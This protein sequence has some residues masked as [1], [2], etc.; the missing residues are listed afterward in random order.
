LKTNY[1][2]NI[3]LRTRGWGLCFQGDDLVLT[4]AHNRFNKL[5][6]RD[7]AVLEQF[8]Q[9]SDED[10]REFIDEFLDD[11]GLKRA[12]AFLGVPREQVSI[13]WLDFPPEAE[14]TLD[15]VIQY[16]LET[17][18]PGH[19]ES[20]DFFHQIIS[21]T[22]QLKV[23]V[24]AV[25][26]EVMGKLF[27]LIHRWEIKLAGVTL[28]TLALVNGLARS[29]PEAFKKANW[30]LIHF[31]Q[32]AM[33]FI[34]IREGRLACSH[35]FRFQ[36]ASIS[37]SVVAGL[38]EG[39]A[40]TRLD[41]DEVEAFYF[42]GSPS[43]EMVIFL[44]DEI[45]I[46]PSDVLDSQQQTIPPVALG[47]FGQAVTSV[48]D[49]V[50]FRLNMLPENL[51]R[52]HRHLPLLVAAVL[53]LLFGIYLGVREFQ[54]YRALNEEYA[55]VTRQNAELLER[56][57]ELATIRAEHDRKQEEVEAYSKFRFSDGLVLKLLAS[58]AN[59]LPLHT[60]L[61][62]CGVK[63]GN[64]LTIQGES[65]EPF[66]VRSDLQALPYLRDVET[67]GPIS[68]AKDRSRKKFTF[69]AKIVLEALK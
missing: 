1:Q 6:Y 66:K 68:P 69:K 20:Y 27:S 30:A 29:S 8:E 53:V 32:D 56:L 47:G 26:K 37:E 63:N 12:E 28:D 38:E 4:A 7:Y 58:L 55:I 65:E 10:V 13:H 42:S 62:S 50:P 51:R 11:H 49:M 60:F 14:D 24:I 67:S 9:R 48:H 43:A 15:E 17:F 19:F 61:T 41:A 22:E 34:G 40:T 54:R 3:N 59:E 46:L 21:R 5:S 18:F 31:D 36:P 25:K 39:L 52:R 35:W 57:Q 45:G 23:M 2:I 44:R 64:E 16:R 33:E